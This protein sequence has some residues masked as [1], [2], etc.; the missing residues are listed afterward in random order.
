MA[1]SQLR[2]IGL[3]DLVATSPEAY[4][5]LALDLAHHPERLAA[6]RQRLADNAP[7]SLLFDSDRHRQALEAA[8]IG[9]MKATAAQA[10]TS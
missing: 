6:L 2:A 10:V 9:M 8:Y 3:D 4:E 1:G 7:T 5:S